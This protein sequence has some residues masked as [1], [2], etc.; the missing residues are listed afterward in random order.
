M[1]IYDRISTISYVSRTF[2]VVAYA[3][4]RRADGQDDNFIILVFIRT[5]TYEYIK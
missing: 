3:P 1:C 5:Y 4:K 2:V